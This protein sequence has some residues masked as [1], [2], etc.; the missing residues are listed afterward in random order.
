[1]SERVEVAT[2]EGEKKDEGVSSVAFASVFTL[3]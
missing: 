2:G 1:M 3:Q